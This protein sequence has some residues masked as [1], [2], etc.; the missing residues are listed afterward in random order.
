MSKNEKEIKEDALQEEK[1]VEEEVKEVF[2]DSEKVLPAVYEERL[3]EISEEV[4]DELIETA[5]DVTIW[6]KPK[7]NVFLVDDVSLPAV[8]GRIIG[9][10]PY[11]VKWEDNIPDKIE[12]E[13]DEKKWPE[14]YEPRC[15]VVI[16]TEQDDKIGISLAKNSFR[17]Q[18]CPYIKMLTD[19]GMKP[20]EVITQ[21]VTWEE[22]RNQGTYNVVKP[23]LHDDVP[24]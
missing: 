3:P 12:Y 21:F 2:E 14:G 7:G 1:T 19:R 9:I 4:L 20:S 13:I 11:L 15:D 23:T 8:I 16:A 6:V 10:N 22:K 24:F 18:F 5:K 17:K